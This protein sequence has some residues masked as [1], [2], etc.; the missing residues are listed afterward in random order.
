MF[1]IDGRVEMCDTFNNAR[2]TSRIRTRRRGGLPA[3]IL[4]HPKL[5][6]WHHVCVVVRGRAGIL[7]QSQP[8]PATAVHDVVK[9]TWVGSSDGV[10]ANFR[11]SQTKLQLVRRSSEQS[12]AFHV[13]ELVLPDIKRWLHF[14]QGLAHGFTLPGYDHLW[15]LCYRWHVGNIWCRSAPCEK[16]AAPSS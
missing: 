5:R 6:V 4:P 9:R 16:A 11:H 15:L 3:N 12:W 7:L 10:E 1:N 13:Y 8:G 2:A 14:A